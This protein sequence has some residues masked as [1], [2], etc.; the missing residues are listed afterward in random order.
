M[1]F[2]MLP[3]SLCMTKVSRRNLLVGMAGASLWGMSHGLTSAAESQPSWLQWRGNRRDGSYDGP[4]WPDSITADNLKR[5]F[6]V[7]LAPSYSGPIVM[8]DRIFVTETRDKK[9]EVVS[10][11][12]RKDGSV[13]WSK[14]WEGSLTVPFF[15]ASNGSWIRATPACD[16][17]TLYVAGIRDVLVAL[18]AKTG[19]ERW[20]ADLMQQFKAPLPAFGFVSSPLIRGDALYVQAGGGVVKLE[21]STGKVLWRVLESS[22]GMYGSAFSSPVLATVGGREQL[23]VQT[24]QKLCGVDP[25]SGEVFWSTDVPAF[26]GMNI[27]TPTVIDGNIFT[28]SYGGKSLLYKVGG[29]TDKQEVSVLWE[30]KTQAYMSSPVV[31]GNYVYVHLRNQ[32]FACIDL[33]TGKEQWTTKPFGQYWSLVL[34][35]DKILALDERGDLLL[36]R[37]NPQKFE[38]LSSRK[39]SEEST[40][41]HLAVSGQQ[42][43]VR[44]LNALAVFDWKD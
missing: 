25:E 33:T 28:S 22:D 40:W 31:V 42:V 27:L 21:R 3:T 12:S 17:E 24:R 13:L 32:R 18:D 14:S 36:I 19:D 39:V 44:E 6:R 10:A 38:L 23:L 30:N 41:A 9:V 5:V 8:E 26:R 20:R 7:P 2:P 34:Q 37:A 29:T 11:L 4:A 1:A 43:I 15:A 16:G 35:G